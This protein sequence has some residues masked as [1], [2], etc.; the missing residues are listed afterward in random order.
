MQPEID[1]D[2]I[3]EAGRKARTGDAHGRDGHGENAQAEDGAEAELAAQ[4]D[5]D[6]PED[7]DGD[8]DDYCA[9]DALIG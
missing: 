4:T 8:G 1:P 5:T 7:G 3:D 2:I 6:A 9:Q